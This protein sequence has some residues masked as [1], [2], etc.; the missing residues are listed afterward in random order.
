MTQEII[1]RCINFKQ[2]WEKTFSNSVFLLAR[3]RSYPVVQGA[4]AAG[5]RPRLWKRGSIFNYRKICRQVK[6]WIRAKISTFFHLLICCPMSNSTHLSYKPL[7]VRSQFLGQQEWFRARF[8][9]LFC[10]PKGRHLG[11]RLPVCRNANWGPP[12]PGGLGYWPA[13]SYRPVSG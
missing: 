5:W 4:W 9:N 8:N 6:R 10:L 2:C 13:L 12:L 3:L 11:N 1:K 7:K